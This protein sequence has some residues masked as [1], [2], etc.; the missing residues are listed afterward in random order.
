MTERSNSRDAPGGA[1]SFGA[2]FAQSEQFRAVFREGMALVEET[3]SYLD[4]DGRAEA[5]V[6]QSPVNLTYAAESMRLTTRLMQIAS[7]LL[8]RRAV[9]E[10]E[11]TLEEASADNRR[12]T[13]P[14]PVPP[15][16]G[17]AFEALPEKLKVLVLA[18]DRLTDRIRKLDML[19][20]TTRAAPD[21]PPPLD[22][23]LRRLNDA[24]GGKS[25]S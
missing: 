8:M 2:R 20:D 25:E 3:A 5:R 15:D 6:L 9:S 10:G 24:F 12:V 11:L 7:W 14:G 22:A 4:G 1:V 19:M 17:Q 13:L 18:C 23:T 21:L 16:R